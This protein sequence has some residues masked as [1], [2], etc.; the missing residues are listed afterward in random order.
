MNNGPIDAQAAQ[1]SE[2]LRKLALL[3]DDYL[4]KLPE[5]L[6]QIETLWSKLCF[7]N[8]SIEAV[9]VLHNLVHALA[10]SGKVFGLPKLS[11]TAQRLEGQVQLLLQSGRV[12]DESQKKEIDKLVAALHGAAQLQQ[13]AVM[14]GDAQKIEAVDTAAA[15]VTDG[16]GDGQLVF[17]VDDDPHVSDHLATQLQA[18]GYSVQSFQQLVEL[19][20]ALPTT[21]PAAVLLD[22]AFPEGSLAG[23]DAVEKI[24]AATG[25][26]TPIL[27]TSARGDVTARLRAL[28]VGGDGY[29]TKP[30]DVSALVKKLNEFITSAQKSQPR[31]LVVNDNV[32]LGEQIKS[33]LE[34][35]G[36]AVKLLVQPL[37]TIQ[38]IVKFKP[39]LMIVQLNMRDVGGLELAGVIRQQE[40]LVDLPI[41]FVSDTDDTA[42]EEK[43]MALGISAFLNTP[44]EEAE[45]LAVVRTQVGSSRAIAR[46]IRG[47]SQ[48]DPHTGLAN[49][50]YFLAQLEQNVALAGLS[51]VQHSLVY[52]ALDHFEEIREQIG[53]V[54]LET[55]HEELAE[56]LQ[57][58]LSI[59]D[60]AT[61]LADGNFAVLTKKDCEDAVME[62]AQNLCD[63]I[64]ARPFVVKSDELNLTCS[65]SI[66]TLDGVTSSV[67]DVILKVESAAEAAQRAGGNQVFRPTTRVSEYKSLDGDV[68]LE[69]K[70]V[71]ALGKR[72]FR[73]VF[74]PILSVGEES[75]D[76][77]EVLL[78]LNISDDKALLPEQFYPIVEAKGLE[79]D[80]E[81]WTI[82]HAIDRLSGHGRARVNARFFIKLSPAT[83][84]V[85][86]F[87]PWISNCLSSSRL[88]GEQQIIFEMDE[89]DVLTRINRVSKFAKDLKKVNCGFAI[90]R[91]GNSESSLELLKTIPVDY[92]KIGDPFTTQLR[93]NSELRDRVESLAKAAWLKGIEVIAV[94]VD[95]PQTMAQLWDIGVRH[96]QG[97][98]VE[99]PHESLEFDFRKAAERYLRA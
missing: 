97:Y 45:L 36:Y 60:L 11:Q 51:E 35:H 84:S 71:E 82:E 6:T 23:I 76:F 85:G 74:Q 65:I 77:F 56:V 90:G 38:A 89:K 50:K 99:D 68:S 55:L 66:L 14:R 4:S 64:S 88:R 80:V 27:F 57:D 34:Q 39:E 16:G 81:R 8:W 69:P 98:Y 59:S 79:K 9:H 86:T 32:S 95:S 10:G 43:A 52:I 12:P 96:F 22:V 72:A 63:A 93:H 49:R 21:P 26:R 54:G 87:L 29:F 83:L 67:Q 48:T 91:F 2:H 20:D 17:L 92:V 15:M 75:E 78:R 24:R 40:N 37:D 30:I 28:R 18:A 42:S 70:I 61:Q 44:V 62:F 7:F 33:L 53:I 13:A 73:L 3:K 41:T 31:V 46:Q 1:Q 94:G 25:V 58:N 5:K 19:F 47:A